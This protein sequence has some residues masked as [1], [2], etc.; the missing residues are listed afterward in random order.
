M[1][2]ESIHQAS[3]VKLS[4]TRWSVLARSPQP[5]PQM[6]GMKIIDDNMKV[7]V[8][9]HSQFY[10]YQILNRTFCELWTQTPMT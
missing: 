4:S 5:S 10:P 7:N 8:R 9:C 1:N 3:P 6:A 2:G